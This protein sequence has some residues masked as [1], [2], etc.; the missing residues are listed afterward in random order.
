MFKYSTLKLI[1]DIF[2]SFILLIIISPFILLFVFFIKLESKG[3][4][5]YTQERLGQKGKIF[6]LYKLRSMT[7][8]NRI[9]HNQIF[10]GNA[11]VT[12]VGGILRRFKFDELPQLLNIA[13]GDMSFIGPRPCLPE[14]QD[15]FDSNG[16]YRTKV[17]PGLSGLAQIHGNIH[18]SWPERWVY[19][20]YYVEHY[21][22]TLD[23]K[24]V[25]KTIVIVLFGEEKF[26][27]KY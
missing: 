3:P 19:D 18:L 27:K 2:F 13:K 21:N 16:K 8:K 22:M 25:L 15:K 5:F 12:R 17:R 14:L 4:V 24:I 6:K 20:R 9:T 7:H 11:E 26:A 23:F 1:I 10:N